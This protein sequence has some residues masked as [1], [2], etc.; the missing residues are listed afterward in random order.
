MGTETWDD[1]P[2]NPGELKSFRISEE[3]HIAMPSKETNEDQPHC[4]L[5]RRVHQRRIIMPKE[6]TYTIAPLV[7][8]RKV[9]PT[10]DSLEI[11]IATT[12][13][14]RYRIHKYK[15]DDD[16]DLV[17]A[18]LNQIL[19]LPYQKTLPATKAFCEADWQRRME[20]GLKVVE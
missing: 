3:R 2:Q 10:A 9:Y 6:P 17:A 14:G 18:F 11:W 7:W 5:L 20:M 13:F 1:I 12:G 19:V 15:G 16:C 8:G 4:L